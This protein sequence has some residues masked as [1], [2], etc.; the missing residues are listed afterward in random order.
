[1]GERSDG[2]LA[3]VVSLYA[4]SCADCEHALMGSGGIYCRTYMEEIWNEK[5]AE[6][7]VD[8][9]PTPWARRRK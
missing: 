3:E 5:T 7:C 4:A 9:D 6:D 8:F 2:P 1:M